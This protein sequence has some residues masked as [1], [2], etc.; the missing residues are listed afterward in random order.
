[1]GERGP[2]PKPSNL[3]VLNGNPGKRKLN[4]KEPQ[5]KIPE[6]VPPAPTTLG[7]AG[8][9]EWRRLAPELHILG[10][11]TVA[12]LKTFE[13]YC[14]SFELYVLA[15]QKVEEYGLT[16]MTDKGNVIQRP[17]V[18]IMNTALKN[19]K[20]FAQEF[21]LTPSSRT[22]LTAQQMVDSEDP[23]AAFRKRSKDRKASG[24]K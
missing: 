9:K 13:A 19:M 23:I 10:L 20:S 16:D 22:N 4:D 7:S 2:S 12:D 14:A 11:L 21:G 17:E 1:M 3:K 5:F 6:K 8:K 15:K 18:G 24:D